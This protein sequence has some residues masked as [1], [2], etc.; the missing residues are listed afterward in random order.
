MPKEF[1]VQERSEKSSLD[2]KEKEDLV[3]ISSIRRFILT[4][5]SRKLS[6]S[7]FLNH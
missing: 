5:N 1:R 7:S 2:K 6:L 4:N 3:G